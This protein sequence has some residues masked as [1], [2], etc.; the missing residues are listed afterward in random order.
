MGL[1]WH[2][3]KVDLEIVRSSG[4]FALLHRMLPKLIRA[5]H[6]ILIFCQMTRLMDVMEEYFE[7][8]GMKWYD[9]H[10]HTTKYT[11]RTPPRLRDLSP[12]HSI[13]PRC[14]VRPLCVLL[15]Y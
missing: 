14:F 10:A 3:T 1:D 2:S 9:T 6:R 12:G 7:W 4:K 15:L 13:H 11:I 5:G 8:R